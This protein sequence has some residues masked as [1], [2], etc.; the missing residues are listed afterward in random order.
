[1]DSNE[2]SKKT[3]AIIGG[4]GKEGKGLAYRWALAGM[5]IIIGS[6]LKEKAEMAAKEVRDKCPQGSKTIG[7]ENKEAAQK[8]DIIVLTIPF[9]AHRTILEEIKTYSTGKIFLDVSVPLIPPKI[10]KVQMPKAGSAL[11]EAKEIL[12]ENVLVASAFQNISHEKLLNDEE[13]EC[14]VL[15]C[16]ENKEVRNIIL[17]LVELA[18]LKGWDAGPIENSVVIEGM[19]SILLGINKQFGVSSAGIK[20]SGVSSDKR[21]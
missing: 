19:T 20:I 14:D 4:T 17:F 1:V 16:G 3:I 8:G 10:T 9:A 7:L 21:R 5:N 2:I 15:V 6:R 18:G 13:I 12:G 11:Q